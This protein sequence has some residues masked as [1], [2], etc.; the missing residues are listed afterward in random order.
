[1]PR[2]RKRRRRRAG[3]SRPGSGPEP[4][5]ATVPSAEPARRR[6]ARDEP[7]PA[8]WGSFPLVEL[9]V[10][11][12][13]VMLIGGFVV[14]GTRGVV[15]IGVGVAIGSV[16]GL[17]LSVREHF[18]GYRS[19]TM[20]LALTAAVATIALLTLVALQYFATI[21][22]VIPVAIG[23]GVFGLAFRYLRAAF[24]R[25]SGGYSFRIGRMSG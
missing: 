20:L 17:E 22:I 8:P 10:L 14:Q 24:R 4:R 1:M 6:V 12:A 5:A 18:S 2:S 16:A 23:A 19:H 13:L 11:V 3:Y 25:A 9:A 15:M 21:A 7:P